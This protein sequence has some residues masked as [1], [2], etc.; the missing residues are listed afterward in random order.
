MIWS[1]KF[2]TIITFFRAHRG[3]IFHLL[4]KHCLSINTIVMFS[5]CLT[6]YSLDNLNK[7][8]WLIFKSELSKS[9][10]KLFRNWNPWRTF[11][12]LK[13][14]NTKTVRTLFRESSRDDRL[15][16][17]PSLITLQSP[18]KVINIFNT[19]FSDSNISRYVVLRFGSIGKNW[20]FMLTDYVFIKVCNRKWDDWKGYFW[21][22]IMW[23]W[24][25][26]QYI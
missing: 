24:S 22:W 26:I 17:F 1:E 23:K 20:S 6:R 21:I 2:T 8:I 14:L 12:E 5:V 18:W 25:A 19:S 9:F 13:Y 7:I 15:R 11:G 3:A 16:I 10:R 4:L